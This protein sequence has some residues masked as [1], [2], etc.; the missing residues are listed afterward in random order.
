MSPGVQSVPRGGSIYSGPD[1]CITLGGRGRVAFDGISLVWQTFF[2]PHDTLLIFCIYIS[3]ALEL[4]FDRRDSVNWICHYRSGLQNGAAAAAGRS[5]YRRR[6]A[7]TCEWELSK[8]DLHP[9]KRRSRRAIRA[10][11]ETNFSGISTSSFRKI[12]KIN[13]KSIT[14][15]EAD[16]NCNIRIWISGRWD[17]IS[18][19]LELTAGHDPKT[20]VCR[21]IG[22]IRSLWWFMWRLIEIY[23]SLWTDIWPHQ[24]WFHVYF[25]VFSVSVHVSGSIPIC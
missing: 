23:C 19:R 17:S 13:S 7:P 8:S 10:G 6:L 24:L 16:A 25:H 3:I 18:R 4:R 2:I 22:N 12:I 14:Y 1:W 15:F 5:V 20:L 11:D 21:S 9:G